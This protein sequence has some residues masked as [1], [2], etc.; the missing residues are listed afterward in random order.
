VID[1]TIRKLESYKDKDLRKKL[2]SEP[3]KI[4]K[5]LSEYLHYG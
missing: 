4:E 5:L 3:E 1:G 2:A